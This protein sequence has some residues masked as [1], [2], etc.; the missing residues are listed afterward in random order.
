MLF[1]RQVYACKLPNFLWVGAGELM[2]G[3]TCTSSVYTSSYTQTE[4]QFKIPKLEAV[5]GLSLF[6]MGL[7]IGLSSLLERSTQTTLTSTDRAHDPRPSI[8]VL[9]PPPDLPC[10]VRMFYASTTTLRT[11]S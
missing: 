3:R 9:W 8:R 1:R 7:G 2:G 11:G 10:F 4:A 6:V 5:A